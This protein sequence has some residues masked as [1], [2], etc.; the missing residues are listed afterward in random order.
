MEELFICINFLE[1]QRHYLPVNQSYF[2]ASTC[3][4]N[5]QTLKQELTCFGFRAFMFHT[6]IVDS[7][8]CAKGK[9][10]ASTIY[11]PTQRQHSH[12]FKAPKSKVVLNLEMCIAKFEIRI[13]VNGDSDPTGIIGGREE[14]GRKAEH[15]IWLPY[16]GMKKVSLHGHM[17]PISYQMIE[18]FLIGRCLSTQH[19]PLILLTQ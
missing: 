18:Y 9:T 10:P 17:M 19:Y 5:M 3:N 6:S 15:A 2:L 1:P 8:M 12:S 7:Q 11:F 16:L 14:A 13:R 4:P